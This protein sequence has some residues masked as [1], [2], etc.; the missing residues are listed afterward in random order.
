MRAQANFD[1]LP[2]AGNEMFYP[3][4]T[5][6]RSIGARANRVY[7]QLEDPIPPKFRH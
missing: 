2:Q 7:V 4:D 3:M 1:D 5:Y 6:V